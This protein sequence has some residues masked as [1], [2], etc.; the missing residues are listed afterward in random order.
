MPKVLNNKVILYVLS[1]YF[2]Y[3]VQFISL[4]LIA[5][6]LGPYSY[7]VWGFMLMIIS[8]MAILN[9]GIGN[10]I[11]VYMVQYKN[12]FLKVKDYIASSF[13]AAIVLVFGLML[14]GLLFY[15]EPN[16]F[17][18][19]PIGSLFYVIIIIGILQYV[20]LIYSNIF[21]ARNH[22]FEVA[23]CQSVVPLSIFLNV[24]F[25]P[26]EMLLEFLV[27]GYLLANV[28]SFL[29]YYCKSKDIRGGKIRKKYVG[30]ILRKGVFLFLYNAAYY[31]ILTTAS[32]FVS[33]YYNVEQYGVY[34]FSYS[35]GHSVLLLL[36]AFAFIIY[37]KVVDKL[38][39]GDICVAEK[40][41]NSI[42]SNYI[43]LAHGLMY[44]AIVLFPFFIKLFPEFDNL[45]LMLN[46][47][48]LAIILSTNSFGYNT[49]LI[50][51]NREKL[52]AI[53]SCVSLAVNIC[54]GM[55][56]IAWFRL[57]YYLSVL[58]IMGSY[59]CFALICSF[60]AHKIMYGSIKG[61]ITDVFPYKLLLPYIVAV[62][63]SIVNCQQL[64]WIPLALF[65]ILNKG[66]IM[67]IMSTVK[68][69]INRP[70]IVDIGK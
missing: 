45:L 56:L 54:L 68:T 33:K 11:N 38:Y 22:I 49:L 51:R 59:I 41:L 15:F 20:N 53:I 43:S 36:E 2:I 8:Y 28:M 50:A 60:Y 34:T 69:I 23:F 29:L 39:A 19:Y 58:S 14:F 12:D 52:S 64:C 44:V 48:S 67:E 40:T 35:L 27:Y 17:G 7:G 1:R 21:R 63:V 57:P 5:D 9:L 3:G 31:L 65:I 32:T 10:S 25:T 6:K 18:K 62:A 37:P 13:G 66:V 70:S 47:M 46:L 30:N 42:R 26:A 61:F 24:L 4:I 55:I 16:M